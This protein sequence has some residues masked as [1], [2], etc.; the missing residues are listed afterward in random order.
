MSENL[1]AKLTSRKW[2]RE[3]ISGRA[4]NLV[5]SFGFMPYAIQREVAGEIHQFYIGNPTGKSWYNSK[6]D[7]SHEMTFLRSKLLKEGAT[8]IECGAH[9]GAQTILLSRWVGEKGK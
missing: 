6:T 8:V 3:A 7:A 5:N 9:H 4:K 2:L 1:L